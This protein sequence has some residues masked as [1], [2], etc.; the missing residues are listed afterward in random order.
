MIGREGINSVSSATW[1]DLSGNEREHERWDDQ[2][3]CIQTQFVKL[4][5]NRK[6]KP[7]KKVFV[8]FTVW[9][10]LIIHS[11]MFPACCIL[12]ERLAASPIFYFLCIML[13]CLNLLFILDAWKTYQLDFDAQIYSRGMKIVSSSA[14]E[15]LWM[16]HSITS[17]T[18]AESPV[19]SQGVKYRH[20]EKAWWSI[21]MRHH[22]LSSNSNVTCHH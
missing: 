3:S 6:P 20:F 16:K 12:L 21:L 2:M 4:M 8:F 11:S 7:K 15:L 10:C 18:E 13:N 17:G 5:W 9:Y 22:G 14:A 1:W 19:S